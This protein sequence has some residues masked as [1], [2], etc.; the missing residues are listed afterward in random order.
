MSDGAYG[1][2]VVGAGPGRQITTTGAVLGNPVGSQPTILN[3]AGIEHF[4]EGFV[5]HRRDLDP[6]MAPPDKQCAVSMSICS[7]SPEAA[8]IEEIHHRMDSTKEKVF[9]EVLAAVERRVTDG[10]RDVSEHTRDS[11]VDASGMR[12]AAM[13]HEHLTHA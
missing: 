13:V 2:I 4:P 11:A 6:A 10:P 8:E 12:V 1:V 9:P 7:P 3:L 5:E